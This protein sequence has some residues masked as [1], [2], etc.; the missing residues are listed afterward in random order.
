MK[1]EKKDEQ[2]ADGGV[3]RFTPGSHAG[4]SRART[5]GNRRAQAEKKGRGTRRTTAGSPARPAPRPALPETQQGK[6]AREIV[7][8]LRA[9]KPAHAP[10]SLAPI[11]Q[12]LTAGRD[13]RGAARPALRWFR[14][15]GRVR[16]VEKNSET[17]GEGTTAATRRTNRSAR[18]RRPRRG[19]HGERSSSPLAR[20][21]EDGDPGEKRALQPVPGPAAGMNVRLDLTSRHI[22]RA[23]RTGMV[24]IG[25]DG[26][27]PKRRSRNHGVQEWS[28]MIYSLRIRAFHPAGEGR[29]RSCFSAIV[30]IRAMDVIRGRSERRTLEAGRA[31]Q[32][33]G[34]ARRAGLALPLAAHAAQGSALRAALPPAF[35]PWRWSR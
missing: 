29:T 27:D 19:R 8:F 17:R 23:L 24:A 26:I 22:P 32:R 28:R 7:T 16:P 14:R 11:T 31:F 2:G 35:A 33:E 30:C 13:R 9:C 15:A 20:C 4:G 3:G 10:A 34:R 21:R 5:R 25:T 12:D 18:G 6:V 1:A